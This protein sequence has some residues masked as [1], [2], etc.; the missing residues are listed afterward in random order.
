[1]KTNNIMLNTPHIQIYPAYPITPSH[2]LVS[3][4]LFASEITELSFFSKST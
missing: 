1:M 3:D 2:A 4:Y